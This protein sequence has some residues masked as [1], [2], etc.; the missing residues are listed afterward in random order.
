MGLPTDIVKAEA[1]RA[2]ATGPGAQVEI[3][4]RTYTVYIGE[5]SAST[6]LELYRQTGITM[7]QVWA[8]L[9]EKVTFEFA[10]VLVWVARRN[11]GEQVTVAEVLEGIYD[12][13]PLTVTDVAATATPAEPVADAHGEVPSPNG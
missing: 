2:K 12:D 9:A 4:G 11:A 10:A 3:D 7:R 5:T 1:R 13:T 8:A 6:G